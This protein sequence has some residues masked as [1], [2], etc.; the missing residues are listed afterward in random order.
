VTSPDGYDARMSAEAVGRH[1]PAVITLD[2]LAAMIAADTHGHRYETSLDGGLY[3]FPFPDSEH[4][5]IATRLMLWLAYAGWPAEQLMQAAGVRIPG[6]DGDGGRIPDLTVWSRPQQHAVWL[7]VTDLLLVIEIVSRGSEAI[8]QVTKVTEYAA[9]GIP[10][11]WTVARDAA[12]TVT[13]L[14]LT[15]GGYQTEA[16]MPLAWLLQTAPADHL[17]AAG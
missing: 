17:P 11:Y 7:T 10:Q 8:D 2:D 15:D 1:M 12:H 3:V 4:A 16:Q 9:A 5:V 13:L 6:P 14:R